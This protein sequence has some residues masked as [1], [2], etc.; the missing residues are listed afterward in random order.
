[1]YNYLYRNKYFHIFTLFYHWTDKDTDL[2]AF[3]I[4]FSFLTVFMQNQLVSQTCDS[5]RYIWTEKAGRTYI[6]GHDDT[7]YII[8]LDGKRQT[9]YL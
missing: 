7:Q 8:I 6:N 1:M 9:A 3:H 4:T 5:Q 2:S